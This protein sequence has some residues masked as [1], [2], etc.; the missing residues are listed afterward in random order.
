MPTV[1]I[2][3]NGRRHT[4]QCGE[5]EE[6]RVKR[7]ASY[8]DRKVTELARGSMQVG[9]TRLLLM[10]SLLVADELSDAFDEIKRLQ[11]RLDGDPVPGEEQAAAAVDRVARQI[12]AIA[13]QLERA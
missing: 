8:V 13:A 11:A 5:G 4:V 3:V 7:L 1:E 2:S 10:A 9:D 6:Q 12:D